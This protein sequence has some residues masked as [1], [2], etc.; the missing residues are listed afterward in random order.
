MVIRSGNGPPP[1]RTQRYARDGVRVAL[2]RTQQR[3]ARRVQRGLQRSKPRAADGAAKRG[4]ESLHRRRKSL[5]PKTAEHLGSE[6][7]WIFLD[8]LRGKP[9]RAVNEVQGFPV[10]LVGA[11]VVKLQVVETDATIIPIPLRQRK[12]HEPLGCIEGVQL[13][14]VP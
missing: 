5:Q 11:Q 6:L 13:I 2:E 1:V 14:C 9:H 3:R 4:R 12:A 7:A 10:R 8:Y